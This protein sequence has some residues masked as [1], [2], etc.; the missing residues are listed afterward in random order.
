MVSLLDFFLTSNIF[1]SD[2][3]DVS[4]GTM[5][6][7]NGVAKLWFMDPT[8]KGLLEEKGIEGLVKVSKGRSVAA[9]NRQHCNMNPHVLKPVIDI[10]RKDS[11]LK[12][13]CLDTIQRQIHILDLLHTKKG[14]DTTTGLPPIAFEKEI[15]YHLLSD[16]IKKMVGFAR[17]HKLRPHVPRDT[18]FKSACDVKKKQSWSN[19]AGVGIHGFYF[20]E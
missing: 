1:G 15:P 9:K 16:G 20:F 6:T 2:H 7:L 12:T 17:R 14:F 11:L 3:F 18:G 19:F 5:S 4:C 10:M 13:P 8:I